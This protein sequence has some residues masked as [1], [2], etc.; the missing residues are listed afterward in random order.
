VDISS[1]SPDDIKALRE[2]LGLSNTDASGRSPLKPRQLHDLRILPRADD[3]RPTFFWSADPPRNEAPS[4]PPFAQLLW[5]SS[6]GREITVYSPAERDSYTEKGFVT[7]QPS[8]AVVPD[9]AEL[10]RQAL[11]TLSPEDRKVVLESAHE[12]RL[13]RIKDMAS[14]LS[15]AEMAELRASLEPKVQKRAG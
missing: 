11:A 6:T 5:E 1:L 8:N 15:P 3:P 9:S 2:Q 12:A 4:T 13:D 7:T 10:A 14:A